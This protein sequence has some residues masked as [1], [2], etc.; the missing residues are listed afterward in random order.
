MDDDQS[1]GPTGADKRQHLR[2]PITLR[3]DYDGA[4][5]LIGDYTENLSHGGT[6]V[7]TS[8]AVALGTAI[9]LV[10][11]FPGLLEPIALDGVVRWVRTEEDPGVGIAFEPGPGKDRLTALIERLKNRDPRLVTRVV[12]ILI[13]EDN[14]HVAELI[15]EGLRGSSKRSFEDPL[16]F[17][18]KMADNGREAIDYLRAG[19]FDAVII[20]IYLPVMDGAAVIAAARGELG[21]TTLPII[22]VSAGG[23]SA[24]RAALAA[25]ANMFLDKPM[26]L[27]QVIETMR[28]LMHL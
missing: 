12:K 9:R 1:S 20:D 16:Q 10:L 7:A 11:S 18:F 23:D 6:F 21:L 17:D 19:P 25:G 24:R 22:A 5:D 8:R 15:R 4:D 27:R 26:R 2:A 13:V 28:R 3:V 14:P